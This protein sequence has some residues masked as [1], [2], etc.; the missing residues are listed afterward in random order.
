MRWMLR[1]QDQLLI[2]AVRNVSKLG[3]GESFAKNPLHLA[4]RKLIDP[5]KTRLYAVH[6][7]CAKW[8]ALWRSMDTRV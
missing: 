6:I 4:W 2:A 7:I 1:T 5:Y 8:R 3:S